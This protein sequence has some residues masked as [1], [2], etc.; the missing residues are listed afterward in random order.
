[1]SKIKCCCKNL[2]DKNVF[3][4]HF[5]TCNL[6]KEKFKDFD[7]KLS[8]LLKDY[9]NIEDLNLIKY[10]LRSFIKLINYKLEKYKKKEK[11]EEEGES[12]YEFDKKKETTKI[13]NKININSIRN[14]NKN[15]IIETK[16]SNNEYYYTKY[17][18]QSIFSLNCMRNWHNP[19]RGTT[20]YLFYK[21]LNNFNDNNKINY[22][23]IID[24]YNNNIASLY[25]EKIP[26]E[27]YY[28]L[29]NYLRFLLNNNID[30]NPIKT[31]KLG[32]QPDINYINNEYKKLYKDFSE[33]TRGSVC[34]FFCNIIV[35]LTH[36]NDCEDTLDF[37]EENILALDL[38][39]SQTQINQNLEIYLQNYF[40]KYLIK[41]KHCQDLNGFAVKKIFLQSEVLI[42]YLKRTNHS[43]KC[44]V[45]FP[46]CLS[47]E[48]SDDYFCTFTIENLKIF[49]KYKLKACISSCAYNQYIGYIYKNN[50]WY[51]Y[52]D[53]EKTEIKNS[54]IYEFEPQILIYEL[55]SENNSKNTEDYRQNTIIN[56]DQNYENKLYSI[57]FVLVPENKVINLT[58]NSNDIIFN[59]F[60]HFYR[61]AKSKFQLFI[62]NKQK[63]DPNSKMTLGEFVNIYKIK[64]ENFQIF[65]IR[66]V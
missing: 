8:L 33:K 50:T 3:K 13:L 47:L 37:N 30:N 53:D 45:V 65:A 26:N 12:N 6:F 15:I 17:L 18:F 44:D 55:E 51:I 1:M 61:E 20:E 59:I 35:N 39:S 10:L 31:L 28:F 25:K 52:V 16:E 34:R 29:N 21:E 9:N 5:K 2:F 11:K 48:N 7:C 19:K 46:Y 14:P 66:G 41:C 60:N 54:E 40:N 63:V 62:C 49:S 38:S 24:S 23:Y 64:T 32:I 57:K 27:P 58:R 42:I 56:N 36:C 4:E 22:K 43:Y